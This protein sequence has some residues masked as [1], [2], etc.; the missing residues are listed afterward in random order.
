[1]LLKN[2]LQSL[3]RK[4]A[5]K[6]T[7]VSEPMANRWFLNGINKRVPDV[8]SLVSLADHLDLDNEELGELVRD[9]ACVRAELAVLTHNRLGGELKQNS[10]LAKLMRSS[11]VLDELMKPE[12]EEESEEDVSISNNRSAAEKAEALDARR[13]K[14]RLHIQNQNRLA[15]LKELDR[16][17]NK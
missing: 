1:M 8:N 4:K 3:G 17:L 12:S 5:A 15:Q 7:G 11:G 6:V 13:E 2:A 14:Q 10:L 16:L 9:T